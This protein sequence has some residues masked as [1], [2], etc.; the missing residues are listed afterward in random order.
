MN[1]QRGSASIEFTVLV[2][3]LVLLF[4][5]LVGGGR[6]WLARSAVESLA[7]A[8]ARTASLERD[9]VAAEAGARRLVEVQAA[10]SGLR[11]STLEVAVDA[12]ALSLP[13]GVAATVTAEVRCDVPMGD[14]LVP[15]W[16]GELM[17]TAAATAVV[18]R[19]RGR[20]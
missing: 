14:V 8:A 20:K 12:S 3:V 16:P 13:A 1:G 7:G 6:V 19:Y 9:A 15:G 10:V 17:V 11:C 2:P 5:L 18:D 4:S